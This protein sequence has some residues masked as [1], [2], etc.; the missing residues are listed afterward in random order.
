[1]PPPNIRDGGDLRRL[2]DLLSCP[3]CHGG[4]DWREDRVA[5][6]SC[7]KTYA[8]VDGVPKLVSDEAEAD[9]FK[10]QQVE[11]HERTRDARFEVCRPGGTP[12]FYGWLMQEKYRRSVLGLGR[13][14]EG[15]TVVTVCAGS[16]MD[17]EFLARAG[18]KVIATDI[19]PGAVSRIKRRADNT[20]LPILP[21]VADAER[22]PIATA[23][24]DLSYVHDGLHHL[25]DPLLGL[26]EMARVSMCG[27]S[28]T[29]PA[30]A[31]VTR[32]AVQL[33][34]A[35]EIEESGNRVGR[36]N[37]ATLVRALADHG[38]RP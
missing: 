7:G 11:A 31:T 21:I 5:C 20:R 24:I 30:E 14:V 33:G 25:E 28:I 38:F 4:L 10:I 6:N 32:I 1:M 35:V 12:A 27:L 26:H 13:V 34:L 16:G 37:L 3:T 8:V 23:C 22:L 17:A 2:R 15:A 29:E 36:L 18:A 9:A 19:F